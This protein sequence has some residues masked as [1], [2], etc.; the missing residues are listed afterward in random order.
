M[1]S[2]LDSWTDRAA[3]QP[4][5]ANGDATS[6][7]SRRPSILPQVKQ[8]NALILIGG[9]D[10]CMLD[11]ALTEIAIAE[12]ALLGPDCPFTVLAAFGEQVGSLKR[13]SAFGSLQ[14]GGSD[15]ETV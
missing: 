7:Q 15:S 14:C 1:L 4:V 8:T 2:T 5:G 9:A 12:Q 13:S 11:A 3:S 6:R 10:D